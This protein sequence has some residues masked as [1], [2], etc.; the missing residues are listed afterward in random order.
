MQYSRNSEA[1]L[2]TVGGN[3]KHMLAESTDLNPVGVIG[4]FSEVGAARMTWRKVLNPIRTTHWVE[5]TGRTGAFGVTC[6]WR[7][8]EGRERSSKL[9]FDCVPLNE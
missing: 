1:G 2:C 7:P 5:G 4:V 8:V 9:G 6:G 3:R